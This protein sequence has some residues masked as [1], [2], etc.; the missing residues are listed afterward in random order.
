MVIAN[1]DL[2]Y[3]VGFWGKEIDSCFFTWDFIYFLYPVLINMQQLI[4]RLGGL[5]RPIT[6]QRSVET[7]PLR[8]PWVDSIEGRLL[9]EGLPRSLHAP[10]IYL[11]RPAFEGYTA[12][13][14]MQQEGV[15]ALLNKVAATL[16]TPDDMDGVSGYKIITTGILRDQ[17]NVRWFYYELN[18]GW[19]KV[20]VTDDADGLTKTLLQRKAVRPR[21]SDSGKRGI[22]FSHG[23]KMV[24]LGFVIAQNYQGYGDK[25]NEYIAALGKNDDQTNLED[26]VNFA[27]ANA[28]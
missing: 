13:K 11:R 9:L 14:V 28:T 27:V 22:D 16:N 26:T 4:E 8:N 24:S 12:E 25:W 21:A 19:K 1:Y 3:K 2:S 7:A 15:L 6:E 17:E 23:G 18:W 5:R 10:K 20:E